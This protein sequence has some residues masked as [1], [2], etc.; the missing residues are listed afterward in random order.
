MMLAAAGTIN[1]ENGQKKTAIW[2]IEYERL[3]CKTS[4]DEEI[5]S[6]PESE[7]RHLLSAYCNSTPTNANKTKTD[8]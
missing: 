5:V 8:K 2:Y 3:V 4:D 7:F 6:I 1:L